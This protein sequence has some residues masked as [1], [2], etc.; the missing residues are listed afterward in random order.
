MCAMWTCGVVGSVAVRRWLG[1]VS[2]IRVGAR[3][4]SEE[5][6]RGLFFFFH[7]R[8]DSTIVIDPINI[9]DNSETQFMYVYGRIYYYFFLLPQYSVRTIKRVSERA[10]RDRACCPPA[11]ARQTSK[12]GDGT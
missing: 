4:G 6:G 8:F 5:F 11:A 2:T 12:H 1:D 9:I 10:E 7:N 3:V